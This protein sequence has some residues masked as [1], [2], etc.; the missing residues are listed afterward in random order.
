MRCLSDIEVLSWLKEHSLSEPYKRNPQHEYFLQFYTPKSLKV[1]R[2]FVAAYWHLYLRERD[3]LV[4]MTDW[5]TYQESEMQSISKIRE[6]L[7]ETRWLI[8]SPG[9]HTTPDESNTAMQL[10]VLS[11]DYGWS[12]FLYPSS[13][14]AILFNWEGAIFDFWTN[15]KS[16][17]ETLISLL[18]QFK[19]QQIKPAE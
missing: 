2:S 3:V 17:L 16:D 9:Y 6:N 14:R 1:L 8:K 4:H 12:S 15:S 7:G 13:D 18:D 11:V 19:I 10:F 5:S